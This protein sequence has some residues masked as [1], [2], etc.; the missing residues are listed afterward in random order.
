MSV[1]PGTLFSRPRWRIIREKN[2]TMDREIYLSND[3]LVDFRVEE[4][5]TGLFISNLQLIAS[6]T[7]N[8]TGSLGATSSFFSGVVT[9]SFVSASH[10]TNSFATE[11][12]A[13][14]SSFSTSIGTVSPMS[15]VLQSFTHSILWHSAHTHSAFSSGSAISGN[16]S[17]SAEL[18]ETPAC[19]GHYEGVILGSDITTVFSSSFSESLAV[20]E[21]SSIATGS[22]DG[23]SEL[24][25]SGSVTFSVHQ[26][27]TMS[28]SGFTSSLTTSIAVPLV[29]SDDRCFGVFEIIESGSFLKASTPMTLRSVRFLP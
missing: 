14:T 19:S 22:N 27:T 29:E 10:L 21:S 8:P 5:T 24:V 9:E 28:V 4:R 2:R 13:A 25:L 3:H 12:L 20:I 11:V 23:L 16:V 26:F 6:L 15:G 1:L 17:L 7:R 18:I